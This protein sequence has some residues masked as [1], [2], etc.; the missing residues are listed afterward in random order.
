MIL[1]RKS[2]IAPGDS[3]LPPP[4]INCL[5]ISNR[6]CLPIRNVPNSSRINE[7]FVSNR[8]SNQAK[9]IIRRH[10]QIPAFQGVGARPLA[11]RNPWYGFQRTGGPSIIQYPILNP[12]KILIA[13]PANRNRLNSPNINETCRSNRNKTRGARRGKAKDFRRSLRGVPH[14]AFRE[15]TPPFQVSWHRD[16]PH[17]QAEF[18]EP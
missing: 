2:N 8:Q 16:V 1:K 5:I 11:L 12:W 9:S 18:R 17:R 3:P 15:P 7:I 4:F 13:T 14:A 10:L 6:P